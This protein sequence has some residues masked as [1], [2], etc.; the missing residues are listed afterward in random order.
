MSQIHAKNVHRKGFTLVEIVIVVAIIAILAAIAIPS[1]I[2]IHKNSVHAELKQSMNDSYSQF[3]NA[4]IADGKRAA[5]IQHY[6]F[7]KADSVVVNGGKATELVNISLVCSWDGESDDIWTDEYYSLEETD[8]LYP[9][10]YGEF[11]IIYRR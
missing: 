6:L 7:V 3:A 8:F 5:S 10:R 4:Q 11:F 9:Q 2:H 1:F